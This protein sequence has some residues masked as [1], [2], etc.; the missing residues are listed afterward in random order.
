MS[1]CL[2]VQYRVDGD[3]YSKQDQ[4]EVVTDNGETKYS[5]WDYRKADCLWILG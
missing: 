1:S 5:H 2:E 3:L 4:G